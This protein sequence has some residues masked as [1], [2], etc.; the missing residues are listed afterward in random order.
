MEGINRSIRGIINR[1]F[2]FQD[3]ANFRLQVLVECRD[4]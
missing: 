1:A 4:T 3:F 2:G